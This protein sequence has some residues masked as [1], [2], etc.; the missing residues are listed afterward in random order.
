M[1]VIILKLSTDVFVEVKISNRCSSITVGTALETKAFFRSCV[2]LICITLR[3][4]FLYIVTF[5]D[6]CKSF[7]FVN[8]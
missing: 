3:I 2:I 5:S 1:R 4:F 6:K 8:K 7:I